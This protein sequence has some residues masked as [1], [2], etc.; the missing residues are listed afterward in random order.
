M[1]VSIITP[2]FNYGRFLVG[3]IA[4][5]VQQGGSAGHDDI[6]HIVVDAGSADD[7]IALLKRHAAAIAAAAG[8]SVIGPLP[9]DLSHRLEVPREGGGA[10]TPGYRF[11]WVSEPDRGQTHAI[12]KGL[13]HATG[14]VV[15]WL[16]AD[17]TYRPSALR[18]VATAFARHPRWDLLYGEVDFVKA[19]GSFIRTKHD[20][21]FS[22]GVLLH[23]GCY[24]A[25][26]ATFWRRRA[27]DE[28]GFLDERYRVTMDYEYW[29]RLAKLGCRFGFV[30]RSLAT[31]A[32]HADNVSTRLDALRREELLV[33]R[34]LY[35]PRLGGGN[36]RLVAS[37]Y[38]LMFAPWLAVRL[39]LKALRRVG[40][41]S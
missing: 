32:W 18:A 20:H 7:S 29:M 8:G 37:Y 30:P 35:G 2:N 25:S 24:L 26:A 9:S 10:S 40:H 38:R 3:A 16:N 17:E 28:A 4:S 33:V 1:R 19:D 34:R 11:L 27:L 22:Y 15:C 5:V 31:F 36:A 23:Y 21:P 12:N 41:R 39:L 14:D 13:R 6:E